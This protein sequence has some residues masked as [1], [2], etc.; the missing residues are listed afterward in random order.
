MEIKKIS[1]TPLIVDNMEKVHLYKEIEEIEDN[2]NEID[3]DSSCSN[4]DDD[5]D[6]LDLE[7][8]GYR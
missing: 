3:N 7:R 6:T 8:L 4:D 5:F 1:E 2:S